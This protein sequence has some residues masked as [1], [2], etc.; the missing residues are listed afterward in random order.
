MNESYV[1]WSQKI[2]TLVIRGVKNIY[3]SATNIKTYIEWIVL[4]I[5][6]RSL[7]FDIYSQ[8][9]LNTLTMV[10]T[11]VALGQGELITNNKKG[12]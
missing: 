1:I 7:S 8:G 5:L 10:M 6:G 2:I 4:D 12:Q 3:A 11:P 9:D